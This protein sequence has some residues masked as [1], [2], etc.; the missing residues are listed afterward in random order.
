MVQFAFVE[1]AAFVSCS[2]SEQGVNSENRA[3]R[4]RDSIEFHSADA[5]AEESKK[6]R[7][8]RKE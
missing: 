3:H 8:E 1:L 5:G 4:P 2:S 7:T 6:C